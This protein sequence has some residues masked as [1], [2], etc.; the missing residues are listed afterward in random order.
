MPAAEAAK[1]PIFVTLRT[2]VRARFSEQSVLRRRPGRWVGIAHNVG[3]S[4]TYKILDDQTKKIICRSVVRPF[5]RNKRVQWDPFFAPREFRY[6]A[7]HGGEKYPPRAE[8]AR[9][10]EELMDQYDAAEPELPDVTSHRS[11]HKPPTSLL[12]W[13]PS[14]TDT[15][16]DDDPIIEPMSNTFHKRPERD[17]YKGYAKLRFSH[18]RVL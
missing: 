11:T 6:T 4:L 7:S 10:M 17:T 14:I 15:V 18:E 5:N 2:C 1:Q 8:R 16:P 3:D 13:K 12:K 9:M